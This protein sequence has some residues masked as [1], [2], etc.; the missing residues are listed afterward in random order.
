MRAFG[1]KGARHVAQTIRLPQDRR[2]PVCQT[3]TSADASAIFPKR[4]NQP[5]MFDPLSMFLQLV[6]SVV[7]FA[8]FRWAKGLQHQ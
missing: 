5:S 6:L 4:R 2:L 1:A 7:V 8:L 3:I